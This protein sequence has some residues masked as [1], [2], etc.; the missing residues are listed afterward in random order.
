MSRLP[1][2][3]HVEQNR[4]ADGRVQ[5]ITIGADGKLHPDNPWD[6]VV[7]AGKHL[8]GLA[9]AKATGRLRRDGK[10]KGGADGGNPSY[11]GYELAPVEVSTLIW[12]AEQWD[13]LLRQ[14][15]ELWPPIRKKKPTPYDIFY[16]GL[17]SI[18][19][20]S[21]VI[22][23]VHSPVPGPQTGSMLVLIKGSEFNP[24]TKKGGK[25]ATTTPEASLRSTKHFPING[26]PPQN[27]QAPG[28]DY[29]PDNAPR[30]TPGT[31]TRVT[32][33]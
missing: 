14:L 17:A 21:M 10:S 4:T 7:I 1:F 27:V 25:S 13:E 23:E 11:H 18:N 20:K 6:T 15:A 9:R 3:E 24:A 29:S 16:P 8:P 19:V 31:D 32:D 33:P 2:W 22:D 28:A 5:L 12:T 30:P 26:E